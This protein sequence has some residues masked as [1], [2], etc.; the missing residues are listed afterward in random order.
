MDAGKVNKGLSELTPVKNYSQTTMGLP[1][2][3]CAVFL[4]AKTFWKNVGVLDEYL[5]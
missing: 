2:I 4:I 3:M 1:L 5:R